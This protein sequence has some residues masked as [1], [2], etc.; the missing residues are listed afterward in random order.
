MLGLKNDERTRLLMYC[1][2]NLLPDDTPRG[3]TLN[4]FIETINGEL[5]MKQLVSK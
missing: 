5:H 1:R 4:H 2:L 3:A